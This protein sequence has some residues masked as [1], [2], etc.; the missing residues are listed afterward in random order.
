M[1]LTVWTTIKPCHS[2]H[3]RLIMANSSVSQNDGLLA[4]VEEWLANGGD[5]EE[6]EPKVEAATPTKTVET[7]IFVLMRQMLEIVGGDPYLRAEFIRLGRE[8]LG[9]GRK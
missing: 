3:W 2:E 9:R 4:D 1:G 5:G 8:R 7:D 6:V